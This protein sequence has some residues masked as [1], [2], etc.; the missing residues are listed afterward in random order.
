MQTILVTGG[1]GFIGSHTCITL[2]E[3]NFKII[4]IDS[5]QNSSPIA[6]E[7]LK[8]L[9]EEKNINVRKNLK[10]F[11][12]DLGNYNFVYETFQDIYEYNSIDA[13]IHFAGLK[14]VSESVN[15][16]IKYWETNLF[17]SINLLKI[18]DRFNSN[19]LIFSSSATIYSKKTKSPLN[20]ESL[21][22]PINPYGNTKLTIEKFLEDI[23]KSCPNKWRICN[24]RYFN[25]IG[26][27]KSGVIGENPKSEPNNIFPLLLDVAAN[28]SK[29]FKIFGNDW[30]TND[31]TCIRD[32]IH[33]MDL[34][35]GH[36]TTLDYLLKNDPQFINFNLG[37]G[38]GTSVLKLIKT[39]EN[40]NNLKIPYI[41][42]RRR[43]G[44]IPVI[45]ADNS[46]ARDILKWN[47]KFNLYDMCKDGWNW[48]C[49]NPNGYSS[50]S[51]S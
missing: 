6:L 27:H 51:F 31:G 5:F 18:M 10:V 39:F 47:P 33:V 21:T 14:A 30:E 48:K 15:N 32:Y 43:V 22:G 17:G 8:F 23:F 1:A 42:S 9:L 41:F 7:K 36:M 13:V 11:K 16:P 25:P 37:T 4:V 49:K 20:E 19:T 34:A 24:L 45:V 3:N 44:D 40:T 35:D 46:K 38:E 26:A 29:E 2:L 50:M 28:K 12:G